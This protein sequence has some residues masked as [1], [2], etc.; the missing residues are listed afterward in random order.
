MVADAVGLGKTFVGKKLLELYAY[1]Q[2]LRALIICPAQLQTMWE[3]EIDESRIPA[4]V[5]SMERLGQADLDVTRCAD[6]EVILV[7]ESHN[8]RNAGTNRYNN[9]AKIIGSGDPKRVILLTATP[10]SNTLWDPEEVRAQ[11]LRRLDTGQQGI[12]PRLVARLNALA[13]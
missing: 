9:L 5:L 3:R 4:R 6:V 10:I 13:P 8:F 11:I 7:D 1:Y 2:R 12:L